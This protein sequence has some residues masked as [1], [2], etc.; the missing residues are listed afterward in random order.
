MRFIFCGLFAVYWTSHI[1]LAKVDFTPFTNE[2]VARGL[3]YLVATYGSGPGFLEAATL[4]AISITQVWS[5]QLTWR[6][7]L[8]LGA[9]SEPGE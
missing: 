7:C 9:E 8:R 6:C 2:G 1:A 3:N 4:L 5:M